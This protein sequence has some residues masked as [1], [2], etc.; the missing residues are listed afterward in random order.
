MKK[1]N[2]FIISNFNIMFV[3]SSLAFSFSTIVQAGNSLPGLGI[4]IT[5]VFANVV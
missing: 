4:K 3:A 1:N 2:K 5:P